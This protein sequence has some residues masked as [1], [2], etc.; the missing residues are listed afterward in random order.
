MN[1]SYHGRV[2]DKDKTTIIDTA[3]EHQLV[4][5]FTSLVAIDKTPSRIAES[6]KQKRIA[7][8]RPKGS[9]QALAYPNTAIDLTLTP[10]NALLLLLLS[11]TALFFIGRKH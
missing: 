5:R 7:S 3:L 8:M 6:L 10:L 2:N 9:S 1:H 4:S 11:L